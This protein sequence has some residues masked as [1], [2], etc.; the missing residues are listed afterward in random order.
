MEVLVL[1]TGLR[2]PLWAIHRQIAKSIDLI[3]QLERMPAGGRRITS[4]TEVGLD[5]EGRVDLAHL[6]ELDRSFE[7][8]GT[9]R[10]GASERGTKWLESASS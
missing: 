2:L 5:G 4:L 8:S 9:P 7:G 1:G 3:V 6:F 10:W